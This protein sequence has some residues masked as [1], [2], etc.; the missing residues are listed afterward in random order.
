MQSTSRAPE[1]SA[2]RSRL[3][4]WIIGLFDSRSSRP[5]EH[6]DDP[7]VLQLRP[8]TS[9]GQPD[10]VALVRVVGLVVRVEMTRA[11]HR[12]AVTRVSYAVDHRDDDRLVHLRG[13]HDPLAD[14]PLRRAL[15]CFLGHVSPLLPCVLFR[16]FDLALAKQRLDARDL[17][18]HLR[19]AR[20]VVELAGRVLEAQVE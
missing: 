14:L 11:L 9:L 6:F 3:S 16:S 10:A 20:D 8:W 7:P 13:H 4:C 1:L 15:R 5:F 19:E 17:A 18:A 2:T 12:L